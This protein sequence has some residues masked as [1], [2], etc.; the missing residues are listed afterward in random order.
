MAAFDKKQQ[1][2]NQLSD[3]RFHSGEALG[4][5][6][7][8][9]RAAVSK[10]I[11]Q[12]IELGVEIF[13]V[14][15]K[16]YCLAQDMTLLDECLIKQNLKIANALSP[17]VEVK[18]VI[19][20][21]N[22]YL[23]E[24]VRSAQPPAN[25]DCVI[26]ECQTAGR[27]RRGRV[28]VSPFGSHIY[29][30]MYWQLDGISHAMGL[31]IAVGIA[32]REAICEQVDAEVKLKWPNDLLLDDKKLAGILVELDGQTDGPC[33]VVIGIGINVNMPNGASAAIDQPW[34]DI[35][36]YCNGAVDRNLLV[37]TLIDKLHQGLKRFEIEGL[38]G[39]VEHWNAHDRYFNQPVK[40]LMGSRCIEGVAKGIDM[41]GGILLVEQG[42][43]IAKPFYG[44]EISLRGNS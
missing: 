19:T 4:S 12:L 7:G 44:G 15:G 31:S 8:I 24:K 10:H 42:G 5:L 36:S 13:R 14:S 3:G 21:T 1:I 25:G 11:H 32:V 43:E 23:L 41:Q 37:A 20:S 40:L 35:A 9:S 22:D 38:G 6:L 18:H 39:S 30:S 26:A 27:G 28:W 2:L 34:A 33:G 29:F 17:K 16:G